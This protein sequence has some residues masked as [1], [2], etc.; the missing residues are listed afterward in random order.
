MSEHDLITPRRICLVSRWKNSAVLTAAA[1]ALLGLTACASK[2]TSSA[3]D[4]KPAVLA[5][6][7][8][9]PKGSLQKTMDAT[10]K[11]SSVTLTMKG[12]A[13]GESVNG[14]GVVVLGSELKAELT[15]EDAKEGPTTVRILGS[16]FYVQIPA[17]EQ[18]AMDGK[19]WMKMDLAAAGADAA[20]VSR[21]FDDID[22]VKQLKTLL[23]GDAVTV[24]GEEAV[25][26]VQAV[27]YA[28]TTPVATYLA[29]LDAEARAAVEKAITEKGIK[30]VKTDLWVDEQYQLRRA[31]A[32][33]GELSDVTVDYSDYGKS[34]TVEAPPA[35][36]TAD[37]AELLKGLKNPNG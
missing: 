37:I 33:M 27:H 13:E 32:V 22:P 17:A 30:E 9:D 25:G 36:E 16:V 7:A 1:L 35:A 8:S 31:H 29:E 6:L 4:E 19:K 28:V 15:M 2:G 26:G 12:T 10:S 14:R 18:A 23:A 11:A 34:A 20:A 5:L 24:V 21:Q 3:T